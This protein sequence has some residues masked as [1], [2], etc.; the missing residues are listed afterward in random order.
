[1]EH[2]AGPGAA[3]QY[4]I[5][6]TTNSY[7]T[8]IDAGDYVSSKEVLVKIIDNL[9]KYS[10]TQVFCYTWF[11]EEDGNFFVNDATLL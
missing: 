9:N 10:Q 5:E 3:R 6:H 11:N 4:A 2:N 1:L 7:V 8:F